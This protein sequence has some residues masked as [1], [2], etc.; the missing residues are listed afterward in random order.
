[1]GVTVHLAPAA[2]VRSPVMPR[3]SGAIDAGGEPGTFWR[4][5]RSVAPSDEKSHGYSDPAGAGVVT[6][7]CASQC[8]G[9]RSTCLEHQLMPSGAAGFAIDQAVRDDHLVD[10][11]AEGLL[12]TIVVIYGERVIDPVGSF[13]WPRWSVHRVEHHRQVDDRRHAR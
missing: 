2:T 13:S 12:P 11:R 5:M 6:F 4:P 3:A 9:S 10:D 1:M 8:A 7:G